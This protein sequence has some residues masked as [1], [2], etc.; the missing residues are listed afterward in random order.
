[1]DLILVNMPVV[2][3]AT[4][5]PFSAAARD[6]MVAIMKEGGVEAKLL[7]NY[8]EKSELLAAVADVDGMIIRSDKVCCAF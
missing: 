6:D 2:L 1:M 3:I 5:K 4:E 7:E 8:K